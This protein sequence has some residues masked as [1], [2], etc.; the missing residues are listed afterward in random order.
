[1]KVFEKRVL[2]ES[3]SAL[4]GVSRPPSERNF[5][6]FKKENRISKLFFLN[7]HNGDIMTEYMKDLRAMSVAELREELEYWGWEIEYA[8]SEDHARSFERSYDDILLLIEEKEGKDWAKRWPE[9]VEHALEI[10]R[11]V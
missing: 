5:Y 1:M 2:R 10:R 8:L 11:A 3:R 7:L 6:L 9:C 4:G